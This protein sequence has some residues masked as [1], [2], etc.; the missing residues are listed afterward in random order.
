MKLYMFQTVPLFIIRNLFT[1]HLSM[2]YVIQVCRQLSGRTR[3][4]HPGPA[5]QSGGNCS[6]LLTSIPSSY[7]HRLII[8][9]DV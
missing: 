3:M 4:E 5:Q 1:V 7:L 8:P 6:S 9:D 2:V